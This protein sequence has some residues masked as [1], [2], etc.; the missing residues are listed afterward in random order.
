MGKCKDGFGRFVSIKEIKGG[1]R[2]RNA[3]ADKIKTHKLKWTFGDAFISKA[4]KSETNKNVFIEP[5]CQGT[6][7]CVVMSKNEP[8]TVYYG[9]YLDEPNGPM[10]DNNDNESGIFEGVKYFNAM[11]KQSLFLSMDEAISNKDKIKINL[12]TT[13]K[14]K[15]NKKDDKT[16][17]LQ[18]T[19]SNEKIRRSTSYESKKAK[20]KKATENES[21]GLKVRVKKKDKIGRT[22]SYDSAISKSKKKSSA[23]K[24]KNIKFSKP[25]K[26]SKNGVKIKDK[27]KDKKTTIKVTKATKDVKKDKKVSSKLTSVKVKKSLL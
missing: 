11:P 25:D 12:K 19:P 22:K 4:F 6:I 16:A 24:D 2:S 27:K 3:F 26:L 7:K 9:L 15:D 1:N 14:Q 21:D 23:S 20:R 13:K 18:K 17:R 5:G 10:I 8:N